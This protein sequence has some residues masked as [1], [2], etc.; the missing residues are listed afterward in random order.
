MRKV[1]LWIA[2]L[3]ALS[4]M[5]FSQI[6]SSVDE[7][8]GR[9]ES[10]SN[11][12]TGSGS[13]TSTRMLNKF[14]FAGELH[15]RSQLNMD[16]TAYTGVDNAELKFTYEFTKY[17][18]I[19]FDLR[20]GKFGGQMFGGAWTPKYPTI[21]HKY[22]ETD[23]FFAYSDI[24]GELNR[25]KITGLIFKIG[26]INDYT[27]YLVK[28]HA[29]DFGFNTSDALQTD[30]H[31]DIWVIDWI[32]PI[33]A[34]DKIFPLTVTLR[35]DADFSR[36]NNDMSVSL[37]LDGEGIQF[38]KSVSMDWNSYYNYQGAALSNGKVVDPGNPSN[39]IKDPT[40]ET[41]GDVSGYRIEQHTFGGSLGASYLLNRDMRIG[42]GV[43]ADYRKYS[44]AKEYAGYGVV[45]RDANLEEI[46][47]REFKLN[48]L[49]RVSYMM[50]VRYTWDRMFRVNLGYGATFDF[51][52]TNGA[53]SKIHRNA[54]ALRGDLLVMNWMEFY[55]GVSFDLRSTDLVEKEFGHT[56]IGYERFGV[57]A[58]V[59][60][61]AYAHM[62]VH[63]GYFWGNMFNGGVED[64]HN[65]RNRQAHF[66]DVNSGSLGNHFYLKALFAF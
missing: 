27:P 32:F 7:D 56:L 8:V 3:L 1:V 49:D 55:T 20:F 41:P 9:G 26:I 30:H 43:A 31:N 5:V 10:E 14:T 33:H 11:L 36:S 45:W 23:H 64:T 6:D 47:S 37:Y 21:E 39:P 48:H 15:M 28:K 63:L 66:G 51:N 62:R 54:V 4:N 38:G 61:K 53:A 34:L 35:H 52:G 17:S 65:F 16:A 12:Q 46:A 59:V 60:F 2:V 25:D 40:P 19:I 50:G 24:L 42:L 18:G 57:D 22:V 58:G 44:S 13:K 29:L